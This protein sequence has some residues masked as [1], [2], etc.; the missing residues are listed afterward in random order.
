MFRKILSCVITSALVLTALSP[1]RTTAATTD[2]SDQ[3][4]LKKGT[5]Q[6][7]Q[8]LVTLASPKKTPL[9]KKGTA[10]FDSN[11]S[12]EK[13]WEFGDAC[14]LGDTEAEK[15]FLEDKTLYISKVSSDTYSTKELMEELDNQAYVVSVEPDY[16]Q[17]KMAITQ[18]AFSDSQWYLDGSG[19]FSTSSKGINYSRAKN[20][21]H[22]KTPVVAVVD[23]GID[24]TN[25]DLKNHM[26]VNPYATLPGI[27]GYD[28]SDYDADPMDED[29]SGHGTHCAGTIGAVA[30]NGKGIA[31]INSNVRLMALKIFGSSEKASESSI[32]GAFNY[33]YQAQKLG[34][35]ITAVNCSWGGG[36]SSS[37]MVS[38]INK[39][40]SAGALFI[41]ASGNNG[42]NQDKTASSKKQCPYDISSNYIVKVGATDT[43]DAP[44]G[45]SNYGASSVDL[46]APGSQILSTVNGRNFIP[47]IYSQKLRDATC[48][49][50]SSCGDTDFT[51]YAPTDI[52]QTSPDTVYHKISHSTVDYFGN[53]KDGSLCIN[54]SA[55]KSTKSSL[56]LYMDVTDLKLDT[57]KTY[58]VSY[59]MGY[60]SYNSIA[61]SHLNKK[62]S[63]STSSSQFVTFEGR[64][65]LRIVGMAG[66]FY[67]YPAIYIDNPA[68]S[69]AN[70]DTS[71]F[72]EYGISSGTS[73]AAPLVTGVVAFMSSH[74]TKDSAKQRK[75]RLLSCV[76]TT[77]NLSGKCRTRG[78][79]DMSKIAS[80]TVTPESTKKTTKK[81]KVKKVK[82][83]KKKATLRYKK[84][85]KLK[86]TVTPKNA[87]NKKVKW[88]SSKKKYA[89]V[90]KSG[91]VK[92]KKKGIGHTVKIYAK[93]KD[94]SR[95]KAYCKVKIK[96]KKR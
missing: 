50:Y 79:L 46:F 49:F 29:S 42:A 71:T 8:V 86:A 39:I 59:D 95:K 76:R 74:F 22:S 90:S 27:Y 58:Y 37:A 47:S 92:A 7:G 81:I 41:F 85:L 2:F 31:G 15:E 44:A 13:S 48:S 24:Y 89:T 73:M 11:I 26:W 75:E 65:Y 66:P 38:L 3:I 6:E 45:Y 52:G 19:R 5:Y 23:T 61:W 20:I 84:K 25:E 62:I 10:S 82:L 56:L 34:V 93:A 30:N 69:V 88:Y 43:K 51:L 33:I 64:T 36:P 83:N 57:S 14:V 21:S 9:V 53:T 70:P 77:S 68:V 60:K 63:P 40:G 94:G 12:V 55:P 28:F 67:N 96:K 32:I 1:L 91:V 16:Y 87:T 78:I 17:K 4:K 18:D 35:N 54:I 80:S 72:G